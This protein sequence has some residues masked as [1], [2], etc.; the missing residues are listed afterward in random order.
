MNSKMD[1]NSSNRI[2]KEEKSKC[3]TYI[4]KCQVWQYMYNGVRKLEIEK[5]G[6]KYLKI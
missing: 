1:I 4:Q 3:Q 2:G 5:D 6:R